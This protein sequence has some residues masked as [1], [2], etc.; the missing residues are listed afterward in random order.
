MRGV[1]QDRE[2]ARRDAD[3]ARRTLASR[4]GDPIATHHLANALRRMGQIDAAM[5]TV[6]PLVASGRQPRAETR[7]LHA[8][9]LGDTGRYDEA[10][11]ALRALLATDPAQVAAH[12]MLSRLLPQLGRGAEALDSYRIALARAPDIGLLWVSAMQAAHELD[13]PGQLLEWA[14]AAQARFG[15][16]TMIAVY[17]GMALIRLGRHA[18]SRE[19]LARAVAGEPGYAPAHTSLALVLIRLG[20]LAGAERHAIE[21]AQLQPQDGVGWSLLTVVWRLTGDAREGWLADY[22]RMIGAIDLEIDL[23]GTAEALGALHDTKEAP[24]HQSLRGGTQTRRDLHVLTDPTIVALM[25]AIERGVTGWLAT[26][27]GDARHPFLARNTGAITFA[28]SWSVRLHRQGFHVSHI[29]PKGWLSSALHVALPPLDAGTGEGALVFGV[30][31]AALELD[32]APRRV[33]A[34]QAGRLVLF[35]SYFWHGTNPFAADAARLTVAFDA[36]PA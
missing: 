3:A 11:T 10:V 21:A 2:V 19:Q 36:V 15:D 28:G 35:P 26:L 9:L 12:E 27:P 6:G 22:D 14:H 23:A 7:L 1:Q 4:A 29:H 33:V 18:E 20:D 13:A 31:D 32:L 30:P 24:G 5:A 17:V 16:D 25:A 34:P 8:S